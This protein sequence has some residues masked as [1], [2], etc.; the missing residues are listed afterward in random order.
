MSDDNIQKH[1]P[2]TEAMNYGTIWTNALFDPGTP[3]LKFAR[4]GV[5]NIHI[6]WAAIIWGGIFAVIFG[7]IAAIIILVIFKFGGVGVPVV[8]FVAGLAALVGAK[9]GMW[10]PMQKSTGEDLLTYMMIVVR[11][12][13][14]SGG[15]SVSSTELNSKA[16]G[17]ADGRIVKCTQ[18]LGTQ[19]LRN[20]PPM[21]AYEEDFAAEYHIVPRGEFNVIRNDNYR[22]GLG[23][24]F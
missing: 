23:D 6:P 1:D 24:R 17:G 22:D 19:P 10:S 14:S 2:D 9:I 8:M 13:L 20:A 21:S 4:H 18:W 7:G 5:L 11:Q 3:A 12:R 16:I 15:G